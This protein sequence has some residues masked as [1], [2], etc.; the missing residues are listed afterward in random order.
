M[1]NN[2]HQK[3]GNFPR[4]H[5][6]QQ[7]KIDNINDDTHPPAPDGTVKDGEIVV[8]E[9]ALPKGYACATHVDIVDD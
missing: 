3:V 7:D 5:S 2:N 1:E 9:F 4:E 6:D 8:D